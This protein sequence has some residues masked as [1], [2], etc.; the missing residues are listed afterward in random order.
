MKYTEIKKGKNTGMYKDENGIVYTA[1]VSAKRMANPDLYD[2]PPL[3]K[4]KKK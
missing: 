4:A 2:P 1:K 3:K